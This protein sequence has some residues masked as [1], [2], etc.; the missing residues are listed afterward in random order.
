MRINDKLSARDI[1]KKAKKGS[2][3]KTGEGSAS[4]FVRALSRRQTEFLSYEQELEEL[5][6]EIDRAGTELEREPT[7]ANFKVFRDLI[8]ALTKKVTSHAYRLERIGGNTLNPRCFEIVTVID[9]EADNLYRLIMTQN[10]DRLAITNK[11]MDLKGLVVDF[12]V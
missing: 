8:G 7:I 10:K 5:K 1:E 11:I 3:V 2:L 9:R 4:P 12:L 6:D